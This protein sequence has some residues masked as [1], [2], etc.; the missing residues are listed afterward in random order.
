[1]FLKSNIWGANFYELGLK[2]TDVIP[3]LLKLPDALVKGF[4]KV[5]ENEWD[6]VQ[7]GVDAAITD[8]LKFRLDEGG[9]LEE[10]I[11][12]MRTIYH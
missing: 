10:D 7:K 11:K 1:M 5:D 4:E 8:L 12:L 9:K 3:V 2:N 6:V